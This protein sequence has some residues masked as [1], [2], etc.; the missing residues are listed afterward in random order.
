MI[1]FSREDL[2]LLP[3]AL[4]RKG[5]QFVSF[6]IKLIRSVPHFVVTGVSSSPLLLGCYLSVWLSRSLHPGGPLIPIFNFPDL[7]DSWSSAQLVYAFTTMCHSASGP[8]GSYLDISKYLE[9]KT[10]SKCW[11]NF[12]F[13]FSLGFWLF[14]SSLHCSCQYLLKYI[15]LY[16]C[17]YMC[18]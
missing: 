3:K 8:L 1:F 15:Y 7:N 2:L 11:A 9:G 4:R 6:E 10:G 13:S 16:K 18:N 5:D 17:I 12:S 14:K